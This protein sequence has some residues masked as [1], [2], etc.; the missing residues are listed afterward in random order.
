M[1]TGVS[2]PLFFLTVLEMMFCDF[3]FAIFGVEPCK[4]GSTFK[5]NNFLL[6]DEGAKISFPIEQGNKTKKT[7]LL[8]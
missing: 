5:E 4:I 6:K 2:K 7:E 3:L 8:R 1:G